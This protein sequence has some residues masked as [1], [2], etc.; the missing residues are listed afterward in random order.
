[1][2]TST[3]TKPRDST[4]YMLNK[5]EDTYV[6]LLSIADDINND[7]EQRTIEYIAVQEEIQIAIKNKEPEYNILQLH[8]LIEEHNQEFFNSL[9]DKQLVIN[10]ILSKLEFIDSKT[11]LTQKLQ[12]D[13]KPLIYRAIKKYNNI[14]IDSI[15]S[16]DNL[17]LINYIKQR[18]IY[19]SFIK[20]IEL[21]KGYSIIVSN[22]STT[23]IKYNTRLRISY[24]NLRT[25]LM[26]I[27]YE[28]E[29]RGN[30]SH[31]M[32]RNNQTGVT[33]PVPDKTGTVPQ[34]TVARILNQISKTRS[35]I[36]EYLYN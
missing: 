27:G 17:Y 26:Y 34:G 8:D 4:E 16:D 10:N 30:T 24:D 35:D 12:I 15:Y 29:R 31:V 13:N 21:S 18:E 2:N 1:M 5:I 25:Y 20:S 28:Q 19:Y 32:W 36:T 9:T 22:N 11:I 33:I 23:N 6:Y 7:L 3:N 14:I